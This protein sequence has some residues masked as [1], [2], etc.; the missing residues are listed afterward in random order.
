MANM[1]GVMPGPTREAKDKMI[2]VIITSC[3]VVLVLFLAVVPSLNKSKYVDTWRME[4]P[5]GGA[6]MVVNR[7]G[8]VIGQ[9]GLQSARTLNWHID[10]GMFVIDDPTGKEPSVKGE[11]S[12]N[13]KSLILHDPQGDAIFVRQ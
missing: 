11:L 1:Y 3:I 5:F 9:G 2:A 13:G 7:D 12:E 10:G 4:G 8:T 6:T